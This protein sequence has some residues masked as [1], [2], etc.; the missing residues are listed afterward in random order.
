MVEKEDIL[1]KYHHKFYQCK[2][3]LELYNSAGFILTD[4]PTLI[5]VLKENSILIEDTYPIIE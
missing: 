2:Q 4:T 5:Y 3:E 1:N